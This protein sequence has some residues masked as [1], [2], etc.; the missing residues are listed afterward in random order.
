MPDFAIKGACKQKYCMRLC[1]FRDIPPMRNSLYKYFVSIK[2][3]NK[4]LLLLSVN[5]I[6]YIESCSFFTKILEAVFVENGFF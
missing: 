1:H 5:Y 4:I 2:F 3:F 6:K